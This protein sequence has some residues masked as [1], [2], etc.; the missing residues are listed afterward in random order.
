MG[1]LPV[2]CHSHLAA[3]AAS[4]S[5]FYV[6]VDFDEAHPFAN[7][8]GNM[9]GA[10]NV[11]LGQA[12]GEGETSAVVLDDE[13]PRALRLQPLHQDVR[14]PTVLANIHQ[15]FWGNAR[16]LA[17]NRLRKSQ[18]LIVHHEA[19]SNSGLALEAIDSIVQEAGEPAGIDVDRLHFLHEL[20][21]LEHFFTQELLNPL[22]FCIE[23]HGDGM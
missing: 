18:F 15:G 22:E 23:R 10:F 14:G 9:R 8:C 17:A 5:R 7:N 6:E 16:Q 12:A 3:G 20:A 19:S 13:F 11:K 21:K 2:L 1:S 4:W